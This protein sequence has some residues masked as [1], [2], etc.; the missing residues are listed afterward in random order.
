[1]TLAFPSIVAALRVLKMTP[2]SQA[3]ALPLASAPP[4]S[5]RRGD[6]ALRLERACGASATPAWGIQVLADLDQMSPAVDRLLRLTVDSSRWPL[7]R[8]R[9]ETRVVEPQHRPADCWAAE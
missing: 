8:R 3:I 7:T 5:S 2:F 1:L 9:P 6:A 4:I